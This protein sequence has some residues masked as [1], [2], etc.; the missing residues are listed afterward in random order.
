VSVAQVRE[1][2]TRSIPN[3]DP[4]EM[5]SFTVGELPV[6]VLRG[7]EGELRA[8]VDR[9]VHQGARVSR[10]RLHAGT[11]GDEAGEYRLAEGRSVIKCPW[12]GY[13]YDAH[14][15]SALFDPRRRLRKISVEE[16]DGE[17][18]VSV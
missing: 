2:A 11:D 16:I 6:V 12:H 4:G 15:G 13:E 17:I 10:G 7:A 5:A 18:V 9:C 8:F 14:T 1:R 3:L